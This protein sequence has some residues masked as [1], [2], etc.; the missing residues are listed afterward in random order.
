MKYFLIAGE[1]SGDLLGAN[2]ME[3]IRQ[4]DQAA[5]FQ[6]WGGDL[7][8]QQA[9]GLLQHYKEINIMGFVE[10]LMR[11]GSIFKNLSRCK[12]Q[13]LAFKPD[14]VVFIDYP[15]FNIRIARFAKHAGYKT[16]YFVAPKIWAWNEKRG[17]KLEKYID[18]L[19]LIFPF[20]AD[21]FKK[22]N[23]KSTYVG[24]PLS[25]IIKNFKV[26]HDFLGSNQL[27][28]QPVIALLPGSR[29]QEIMRILPVMMKVAARLPA[30]Q[31]VIA[32]APSIDKSYYQSFLNGQVKIVYNQTYDLLSCAKASIVCS[33]TASLEAAFFNVP[34]VCCYAANNISYQIAIRFVK[35]KYVSLVN[36]NLNR[37]AINEYIQHDLTEENVS[38]ELK[39]VLPGGIGYAQQMENYAALHKLFGDENAG[40][41]AAQI[42]I[43]LAKV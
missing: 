33:G 7:M 21:Y 41:K 10:V 29:K 25:Q 31:F 12:Q 39:S 27:S 42:I 8:Q 38:N 43:D 19:L 4:K 37:L 17:Y 35:V 16:A 34:Q 6:Y 24:N 3:G 22:W 18:E 26:N 40:L 9:P 32:G 14:V 13:I 30:Y 5:T 2:L 11:L 23:V 1:A 20:E 28:N 15:G 36:I